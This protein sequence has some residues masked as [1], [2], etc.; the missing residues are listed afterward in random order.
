M[1]KH[2]ITGYLYQ[3][4]YSWEDKPRVTFTTYE[5]SNDPDYAL[6]GPHSFE[7]EVSDN[8]DPRPAQIAALEAKKQEIRAEFSKRV[9][10]IDKRIS[11]LQA[12]T[13]DA[14]EAA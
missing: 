11:E 7:V 12:I 14:R 3:V 4:Q 13:F 2:T 5:Q 1:A 8:F 9:M 10:E 6:I